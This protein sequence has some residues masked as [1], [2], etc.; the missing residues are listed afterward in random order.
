MNCFELQIR[1]LFKS[2]LFQQEYFKQVLSSNQHNIQF[3]EAKELAKTIAGSECFSLF[4]T[5]FVSLK[6]QR[7]FR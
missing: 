1:G 3:E 2:L 7:G 4:F 5:L 6:A